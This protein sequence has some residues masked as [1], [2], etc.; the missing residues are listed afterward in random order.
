MIRIT[1]LVH[2]KIKLALSGGP[3]A[4]RGDL[5]AA[6]RWPVV[7]T[8]TKQRVMKQLEGVG[9]RDRSP[10]R[11]FE[12]AFAHY[13]GADHCLS[14]VNG[15]AAIRTALW[16]VGVGEHRNDEVICPSFTWWPTV[17]PVTGLGAKVVFAEIDPTTLTLDPQ[18]VE[19]RITKRTRAVLAVHVYGMPADLDGLSEICRDRG[20]NLIEDCCLAPGA[21]YRG[22]H[23]GNFGSFGCF[24]L[25][26]GKGLPAGEGG[27]LI[28]ND[29]ELY[30]RAVACG[31]PK[32]LGQLSE[33]WRIYGGTPVGGV[34]NRIDTLSALVGLG[35]LRELDRTIAAAART[36]QRLCGRIAHLPGLA[37]LRVEPHVRPIHHYPV[38]L[39]EA[40]QTGVSCTRI[41]TALNAEG[42][43]VRRG[44]EMQ[45]RHHFFIERGS[46]PNDLPLTRAC[47]D[48]V[49]SL[50]R[51]HDADDDL[52]DQCVHAFTKVWDHLDELRDA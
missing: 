8:W 14:M 19:R 36:Y 13:S 30:E 10:Q 17:L 32:R 33:K 21:R 4:I 6:G 1:L 45:H 5:A 27:L 47:A 35:S 49:I 37:T 11:E 46:D 29:L 18:D 3:Q 41:L 52:I 7:S 12:D 50:P 24:S 26:A 40:S 31:H 43:A 25:Q 16:A 9:L 42:I 22:R 28:S 48:R 2:R 23:L 15:T 20:L 39:Y 51:L 38:V 34:K 44:A